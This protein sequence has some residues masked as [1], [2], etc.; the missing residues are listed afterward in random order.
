MSDAQKMFGREFV[1][2]GVNG[3]SNHGCIVH[4]KRKGIGTN[5]PCH[6]VQYMQPSQLNVFAH[7]LG[8]HLKNHEELEAENTRLREQLKVA[9]GALEKLRGMQH[10]DDA[11]AQIKALQPSENN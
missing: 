4:G 6:C 7:R 5:G 8:H 3:C 10:A 2:R 1:F 11:L 9:V